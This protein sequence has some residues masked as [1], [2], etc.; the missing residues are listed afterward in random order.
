MYD[1]LDYLRHSNCPTKT[2]LNSIADGSCGVP[3]FAEAVVE[4]IIT[5]YDDRPSDAMLVYR[6]GILLQAIKE[7]RQCTVGKS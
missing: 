6:L 2:L 4:L 7:D 3:E 5:P 1:L